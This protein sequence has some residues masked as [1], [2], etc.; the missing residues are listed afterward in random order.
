MAQL[1]LQKTSSNLEIWVT[2]DQGKRMALTFDTQST[3]LT[4][5]AEC[6]KQLET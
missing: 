3:S 1:F 5:S 2:F 4:N 6:F